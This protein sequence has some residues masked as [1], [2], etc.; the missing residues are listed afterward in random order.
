[1]TQRPN[2]KKADL[3]EESE[4]ILEDH[5]K[6]N[7]ERCETT[8]SK[9]SWGW[10][11][12]SEKVNKGKTLPV[13]NYNLVFLCGHWEPGPW[14][15]QVHHHCGP[16]ST[17]GSA[18]CVPSHHLYHLLQGDVSAQV[19]FHAAFYLHLSN[20]PRKKKLKWHETNT[21]THQWLN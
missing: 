5:F 17:V 1:M 9:P 12:E 20:W 8:V 3:Q 6:N 15:L 19:A 2:M 10:R 21:V 18:L 16:G 14:C 11:Q 7:I 4:S 13:S